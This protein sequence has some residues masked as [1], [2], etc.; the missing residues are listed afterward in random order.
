[1]DITGFSDFKITI[2]NLNLEATI[3]D[4]SGNLNE[5]IH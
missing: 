3:V 5:K 1:V 4:K 2:I